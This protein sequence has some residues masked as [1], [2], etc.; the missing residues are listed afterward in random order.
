MREGIL[1]GNL[2]AAAPRPR[3]A[4]ANVIELCLY[5]SVM[6]AQERRTRFGWFWCGCRP[7][8]MARSFGSLGGYVGDYG[9]G[10]GTDS[11][12][13]DVHL[14]TT[15]GVTFE[16]GGKTVPCEPR[17]RW[18]WEGTVKFSS[19]PPPPQ[20]LALA[21]GPIVYCTGDADDAWETNHFKDVA[22]HQEEESSGVVTEG[23]RVH[24]PTG[25][26]YVALRTRYRMRAL[27]G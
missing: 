18:P 17:S 21:R 4:F 1:L 10:H 24:E 26:E 27:H 12:F 2:L 5:N 14:Y 25:E 8:S 11:V 19:W 16:V 20:T 9:V 3:R 13:A 22:I 15:A 23:G 7:P 6:A